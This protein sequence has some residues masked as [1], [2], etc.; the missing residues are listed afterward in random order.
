MI[1]I[2]KR[3]III[4]QDLCS[5][6]INY[7]YHRVTS[8][9]PQSG[10][11]V[12][13]AYL[14]HIGVIIIISVFQIIGMRPHHH[15]LRYLHHSIYICLQQVPRGVHLHNTLDQK[16]DYRNPCNLNTGTCDGMD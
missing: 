3:K 12:L 15:S 2:L 13:M 16:T 14:A 10:H 4:L 5:P 7:D 11:Q 8:I 1:V 9:R 6:S